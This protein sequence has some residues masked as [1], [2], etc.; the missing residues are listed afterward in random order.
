MDEMLERIFP[1][2]LRSDLQ[3]YKFSPDRV[4]EQLMEETSISETDANKVAIEVCRSIVR[5][6]KSVKIITGPMLRE[7]TNS[8]L[9]QFGLEIERLQN[10]RIG[11]PFFELT[12]MEK[13]GKV[14]GEIT[15]KIWNEYWNVKLI[16]DELRRS[17]RYDE[18]IHKVKNKLR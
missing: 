17:G 2:V 15:E 11:V 14:N 9:L 7:L 16:I 6:S 10:T 1:D 5:I 18:V 13:E 12:K 4:K 3:V 8:V